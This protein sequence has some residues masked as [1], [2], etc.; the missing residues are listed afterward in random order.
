MSNDILNDSQRIARKIA[1]AFSSIEDILKIEEN[2]F[3]DPANIG[4]SMLGKAAVCPRWAVLSNNNSFQSTRMNM[5]RALRHYVVS[6]RKYALRKLRRAEERG[7]SIVLG[8]DFIYKSH[9][10]DTHRILKSANNCHAELNTLLGEHNAV[11]DKRIEYDGLSARV[12]YLFWNDDEVVPIVV[13]VGKFRELR[14]SRLELQLKTMLYIL[15]KTTTLDV[16][17]GYMMFLSSDTRVSVQ[18]SEDVKDEVCSLAN[19]LKETFANGT[20][21]DG[22]DSL[23]CIENDCDCRRQCCELYE[24]GP[25]Q[26]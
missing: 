25:A 12:H 2:F 21:P 13:R 23:I 22:V 7:S 4:A 20:I 18:Y 14:S 8:R 6:G 10:P 15:D 11:F 19:Y 1:D 9:V 3:L 5:A 16:D 24:S 17:R 26:I